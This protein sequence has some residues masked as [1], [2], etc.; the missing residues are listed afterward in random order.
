M[1]DFVQRKTFFHIANTSKQ[2]RLTV[3][4]V[5]LM[6]KLAGSHIKPGAK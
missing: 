1:V 6:Y 2:E 5:H 3:N 4:T